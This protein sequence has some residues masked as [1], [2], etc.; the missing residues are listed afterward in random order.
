AAE[1]YTDT[2]HGLVSWIGNAAVAR[3]VITLTNGVW[4]PV[5]TVVLASDGSVIFTAPLWDEGW[6]N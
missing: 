2:V 1:D 6:L 3:D 5:T 4:L